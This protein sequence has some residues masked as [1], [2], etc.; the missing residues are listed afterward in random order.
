MSS[1]RSSKSSGS[2]KSSSSVSTN[3]TP[4]QATGIRDSISFSGGG[5]NTPFHLGVA[6]WLQKNNIQFRDVYATSGGSAVGALF[7]AGINAERIE[8]YC[9]SQLPLGLLE[10]CEFVEK[11]LKKFL[12]SDSHQKLS[13]RL[14]ITLSRVTNLGVRSTLGAS[15]CLV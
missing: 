8:K 4:S 5:L 2:L 13:G 14:F 9:E 7:V 12:P 10:G 6:K 3:G 11:A 1:V 15:P